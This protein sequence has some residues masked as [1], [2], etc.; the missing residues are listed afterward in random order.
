MLSLHHLAPDITEEVQ[1]S[2]VC[3]Y[4]HH[5]MTVKRDLGTTCSVQTDVRN[6]QFKPLPA[7]HCAMTNLDNVCVFENLTA[8][9]SKV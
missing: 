9:D 3:L 2:V 7:L 5:F 6:E 4:S 8:L 1:A